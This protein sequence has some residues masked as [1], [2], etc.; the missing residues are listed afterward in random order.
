MRW[1]MVLVLLSG[2]GPSGLVPVSALCDGYGARMCAWEN[3]CGLDTPCNDEVEKAEW[4]AVCLS[5]FEGCNG[6]AEVDDD[7]CFQALE[8]MTC[9]DLVYPMECYE[10]CE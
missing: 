7:A 5:V 10:S 6:V 4:T 2:C 3:E 1:L 9:E 8:E